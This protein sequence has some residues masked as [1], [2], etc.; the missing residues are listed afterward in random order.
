MSTLLNR[1]VFR[2]RTLTRHAGVC[3][4]PDCGLAAV[5]AHHI[6]NRRLFTE[7]SEFG[8][9]FVENGAGLCSVHHLA[10]EQTIISATDLYQ[11]CGVERV[12][13]EHL[14]TAFEYDTWG[15]IVVDEFTRIPGELFE[16]EGCQKA[17]AAGRVLWM[18][19]LSF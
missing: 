19:R 6:L 17:L 11:F 13:P 5:D 15:N 7:A 8:G 14:E 16:D 3:V 2:E 12:L 9:Y 18:F 4:V 10:A 1:D